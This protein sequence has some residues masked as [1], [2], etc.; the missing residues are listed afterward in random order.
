MQRHD[1]AHIRHQR[2]RWIARRV[3]KRRW[4][5]NATKSDE[6][7]PTIGNRG[8]RLAPRPLEER[9]AEF[10]TPARAGKFAK[11]NGACSCWWCSKAMKWRVERAAHRRETRSL[12]A[13]YT[14]PG[15]PLWVAGVVAFA[16]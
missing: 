14:T 10:W 12:I 2:A 13:E 8:T 15:R 11:H 4:W 7:G 5:V 16:S 9:D 6:W 1:R 3:A